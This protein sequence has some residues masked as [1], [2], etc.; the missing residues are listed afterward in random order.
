[1]A[2]PGKGRMGKGRVVKER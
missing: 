2:D 1:M